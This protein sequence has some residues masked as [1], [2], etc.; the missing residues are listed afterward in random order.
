MLRKCRF[1]RDRAGARLRRAMRGVLGRGNKGGEGRGGD[2]GENA[3][4]MDPTGPRASHR[5]VRAVVRPGHVGGLR[6]ERVAGNRRSHGRRA[7]RLR[8]PIVGHVAMGAQ[9]PIPATSAACTKERR[10]RQSACEGAG[11][12]V[13][14]WQA[15]VRGSGPFPMGLRLTS[16]DP[17]AA[18]TTTAAPSGPAESCVVYGHLAAGA[19]WLGNASA[20]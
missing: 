1:V 8:P 12:L 7:R 5:L 14:V 16:T 6:Q 3:W 15:G 17:G 10:V 19:R 18:P 13:V 20:F 2:A 4:Q 11:H 9:R